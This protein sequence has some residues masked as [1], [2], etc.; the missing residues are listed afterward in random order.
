MKAGASAPDFTDPQR[1]GKGRAGPDAGQGPAVS[2]SCRRW[3]PPCALETKKFNDGLNRTQGPRRLLHASAR[4][5]VRA[6][7]ASATPKHIANFRPVRR[8]QPL[9]RARTTACLIEGCIRW[10]AEPGRLRGGTRT[11]DAYAEY[12]SEVTSHPNYDRAAASR[13]RVV[14]RCGLNTKG[15]SRSCRAAHAD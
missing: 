15:V 12:V 10:A 9:V 13:R 5:A 7:R 6:K 2:A 11:Q 1:A 14:V 3:T 8:P 4:P